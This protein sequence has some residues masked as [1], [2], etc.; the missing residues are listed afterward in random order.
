MDFA[1]ALGLV[2]GLVVIGILTMLDGS[3]AAFLSEHAL[4]VIFGGCAGAT[5]IRFPMST[6]LHGFPTGM[7]YAFLMHSSEPRELIEEITKIADTARRSGAAA[8]E[9]VTVKDRFLA[10]GIRY[11]AD[12]YD[13]E[14]IRE[15]LQRDTDAF[16]QRLEEGGKVYRAIGDAAP[17]WGM[18]GT[19][20]GMVQMF[21]NM[22]DPSKLGPFMAISLLATLYGALIANLI[23]LPVADKLQLKLEEED[24][25]RA[26]VID[27]VMQIREAKSPAVVREMLVAYLPIKHREAMAAA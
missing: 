20:I 17:A 9:R 1:T 15:T 3:P 11:I 12:G 10:Q 4:I 27:G 18:I 25:C 16:L 6:L 8:L 13:R 14:F 7:R 23:C 24:V 2:I 21:S 19:L 5:L 22:E 26:L